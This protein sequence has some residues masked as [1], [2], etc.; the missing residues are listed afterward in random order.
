MGPDRFRH[1]RV[2]HSGLTGRPIQRLVIRNER[3]AENGNKR[4]DGEQSSNDRQRNQTVAGSRVLHDS[5]HELPAD[6]TLEKRDVAVD[7]YTDDGGRWRLTFFPLVKGSR[8][9]R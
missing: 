5:G 6:L 4:V 9:A 3:L 8:S 1:Q 2:V 7:R